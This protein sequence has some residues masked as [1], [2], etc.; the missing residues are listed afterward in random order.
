[1]RPNPPSAEDVGAPS[2]L[3]MDRFI[4]GDHAV[5]SSSRWQLTVN[6]ALS[7]HHEEPRP[8]TCAVEGDSFIPL[9]S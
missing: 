2:I 3:W 1:M 7:R 8:G 9:K 6:P 5:H 4:A